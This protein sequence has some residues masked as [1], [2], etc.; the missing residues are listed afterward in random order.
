MRGT[1]FSPGRYWLG[2]H[3][4]V[5][6]SAL[7]GAPIYI[8]SFEHWC[9]LRPFHLVPGGLPYVKGKGAVGEN[10]TL[11][12]SKTWA[13]PISHVVPAEFHYKHPRGA[14]SIVK[15]RQLQ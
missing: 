5:F 9:E 11:P 2:C 10:E 15:F 13:F 6:A 4:K 3:G 12:V 1:P 7:L 8:Q 14:V